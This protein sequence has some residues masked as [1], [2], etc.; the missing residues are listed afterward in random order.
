MSV[1]TTT[2]IASASVPNASFNS[3]QNL[4]VSPADATQLVAD[5]S[6]PALEANQAILKNLPLSWWVS[7]FNSGAIQYRPVSG[8]VNWAVIK[9]G[10][11]V[12]ISKEISDVVI[13]NRTGRVSRDDKAKTITMVMK[14][15]NC[16]T[17]TKVSP[18]LI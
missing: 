18:S 11:D 14:D 17:L 2:Y 9:D 1:T 12:H 8:L 16:L 7:S 10:K 5:S 6:S 13:P 4:P 15:N 3:V